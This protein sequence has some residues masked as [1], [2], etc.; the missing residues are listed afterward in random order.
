MQ[1]EFLGTGAGSPS[2]QRNVTSVALKLLE[3]LNEIWLFDAG[4]ATQHQILHTTIRPRKVTK[5][6]ITH[7]HGDHIFGL[8]GFLSS[9]S[10]Q[11]GNEPL[12]IY[13]PVGIKKFVMTALQVSESRLSYPLKFVEIDRSQELFN[14]RGFKVTTMSLDHKIACYGYRIEEADHPGELQVDK[15]RQDNIP[16]GP[17][18]GQL[19]AGKTVKLDDGRV[20]DGKNYIGKPQP[21]RIIAILG[22]TRQTPN[23]VVL[24]H[25]A[26]VLVHEST[27]AKNEAKMAHNYYH[28]TSLQAAEVAKQAGVKK[29]LL[30]HISARY[31]GKAAYQLAYQVRDVVP[32]TR[33]VNDFDVIDV[34]FKK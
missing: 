10:F 27:F 8:P 21:G 15:L 20:I 11:G 14:E 34:P 7:L 30:T 32:D 2:K 33:V 23:A 24:A 28:S 13:G 17:I 12:T 1:L 5:I 25:K 4:E 31:T 29:L 22:D 9:R 16:S 26:D 19:K 18:Y 6:F 3:E